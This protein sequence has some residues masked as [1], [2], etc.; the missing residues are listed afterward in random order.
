[1][2]NA[3]LNRALVF[4]IVVLIAI[5]SAAVWT[6]PA[7]A[8]MS[9]SSNRVNAGIVG[10]EE[11]EAGYVVIPRIP[12]FWESDVPWHISVG[13][14]D[15]DLGISSDSRYVKPLDD[16]RWR[17]SDGQSWVPMRQES[18]E[19]DWSSEPGSGVVYIDIVILLDWL[20]DAPGEYQAD[21]VFT[22]ESL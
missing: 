20:R 12:I 2:R 5:I 6:P 10:A 19:I 4:S 18:E 17:L 15:P 14:L 7:H 9:V 3:L 22:I 13:S 1:V 21:L 8:E 16:L 11:F